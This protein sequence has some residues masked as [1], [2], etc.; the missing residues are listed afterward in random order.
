MVGLFYSILT[1]LD[2]HSFFSFFVFLLIVSTNICRVACKSLSRALLLRTCSSHLLLGQCIGFSSASAQGF[3]QC[4]RV[5]S[6][7]E[8]ISFSL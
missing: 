3:E 1:S 6:K 7:A 4:W 2:C 5:L 8:T